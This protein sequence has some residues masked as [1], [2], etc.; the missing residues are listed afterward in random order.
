[1]K[2]II[3][4]LPSNQCE[5]VIGE[6]LLETPGAFR[7]KGTESKGFIV[8]DARLR[9]PAKRLEAVLT[10]AGWRIHTRFIPATE[11]FK[12]LHKIYP[13]YDWLLSNGADRHSV[14]FA[15]G[16]GVVGDTVGFLAGTFL[17]GIRWVGVPSTLLAQV[18]SSVGGKTAV[19]HEKG[20]N[21]I[22]VFHQPSQVLCDVALLKTLP[23]RELISGLGE[24][25][26][27]GLVFDAAFFSEI[28]KNFEAILDLKPATIM[29][30]VHR[31]LKWKAQIVRKDERD[32]LGLREV[33]NFGH[34]F[35]HALEAETGFK[36]FR[37][38]EAVIWG[39][40]AACHLSVLAGHL[41]EKTQK[42]IDT[43]L[44]G[45]PVP[46]IP[47]SVKTESLLSRLKSDKKAKN[48]IV[49]FVLL[50]KIGKAVL[51]RSIRDADLGATVDRI[52]K[53]R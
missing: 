2:K 21:L 13:L 22:G 49:R 23:R 12:A 38:G 17:R 25:I 15:V 51:D 9:L 20:K 35:G 6:K 18:D 39:M 14:I 33:L 48:G 30:A 5:I 41:D 1:M 43:F 50:Q 3:L 52:R 24:I 47:N 34:T 36:Y 42:R 27:Y 4:N 44:A 53:P 10:Q 16:G 7:L 37:H 28:E 26:K 40:R 32:T 11:E 31:S 46:K 29:R 19:N 45:L 8:A